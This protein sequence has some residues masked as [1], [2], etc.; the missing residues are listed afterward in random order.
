MGDILL[1][2]DIDEAKAVGIA[3]GEIKPQVLIDFYPEAN[4]TTEHAAVICSQV[5]TAF[6]QVCEKIAE[7]EK[8]EKHGQERQTEGAQAIGGDK[9]K[10]RP[11]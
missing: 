10:D 2:L 3:L 5:M 1:D 9:E 4:M 7:Y 8:G 11:V 6:M